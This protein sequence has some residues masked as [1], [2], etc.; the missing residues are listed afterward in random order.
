MLNYYSWL[1]IQSQNSS[2]LFLDSVTNW[3]DASSLLSTDFYFILIFILENFSSTYYSLFSSN[4]AS[5]IDILFTNSL[6]KNSILLISFYYDLFILNSSISSQTFFL[7]YY[8]GFNLLNIF[9]Q[10]NPELLLVF[11]DFQ[12]TLTSLLPQVFQYYNVFYFNISTINLF[13]SPS[14]LSLIYFIFYFFLL[15]N[16]ITLLSINNLFFFSWFRFYS[17]I[18]NFSYENRLQFDWTFLFLSFIFICWLPLLISY[19]D[20]NTEI[21][22]LVHNGICL[23]FLFIILFFLIKYS[24]HYFSFLENSVAEGQTVSFIAKQFVRDISN[25]FALFLRFFLLLFRLNIYDGLDDFLDSYYIFFIDFDEDSYFDEL[26]WI[27]NTFTFFSDNEEDNIFYSITELDFFQDLFSKYFVLLGK[28]LFFWIFILE[29][30]FR[31]S[32]AFY[33]SYLII[34]EVHAVN[35]SYLEDNFYHKKRLN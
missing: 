18:M 20:I 19:D 32:L 7:Y 12:T 13:F 5:F 23:L 2:W 4:F 27:E 21:V 8:E 16:F 3:T 11:S 22:E 24:I 33:I 34:F 14:L 25:S 15:T 17:Y 6:N 28:F 29:E 1:S 9:L 10:F 35:I 30:I 31:V 26:F